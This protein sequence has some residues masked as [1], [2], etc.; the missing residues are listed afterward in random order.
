M[1]FTKWK[2]SKND[3]N[4]YPESPKVRTLQRKTELT[5]TGI[6]RI[7]VAYVS[8]SPLSHSICLLQDIRYP[9]T[10]TVAFQ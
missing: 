6:V 4:T 7:N 3:G 5:F 9:V 2:I 1:R 10:T 8:S